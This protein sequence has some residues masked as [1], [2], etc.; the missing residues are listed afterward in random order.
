MKFEELQNIASEKYNVIGY[1]NVKNKHLD[2]KYDY[3]RIHIEET[4]KKKLHVKIK[5]RSSG[6]EGVYSLKVMEEM[7]KGNI[8]KILD[9]LIFRTIEYYYTQK[10]KSLLWKGEI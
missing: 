6:A 9:F 7:F 8:Q 2:I 5:R 10:C 4:E 1:G 3:F